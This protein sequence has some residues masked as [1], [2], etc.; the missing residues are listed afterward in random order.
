[1]GDVG[2]MNLFAWRAPGTRL[3]N[4]RV[5]SKGSQ[6]DDC[7]IPPLPLPPFPC[8]SGNIYQLPVGCGLWEQAASPNN[9]FSNSVVPRFWYLLPIP[10]PSLLVFRGRLPCTDH[11]SYTVR[12]AWWKGHLASS[13][14]PSARAHH[15]RCELVRASGCH[16]AIWAKRLVNQLRVPRKGQVGGISFERNKKDEAS[17]RGRNQRAPATEKTKNRPKSNSISTLSSCAYIHRHCDMYFFLDFFCFLF[18]AHSRI[19]D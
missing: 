17:V 16:H 15:R 8:T 6:A 14:L 4:P 19:D 18:F 7:I 3:P 12:R 9:A 11:D 2:Q 1:M 5:W 13:L 10:T